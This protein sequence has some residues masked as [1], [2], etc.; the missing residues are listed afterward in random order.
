MNPKNNCVYNESDSLEIW[1]QY[2]TAFINPLGYVIH[3]LAP[4]LQSG[5]A[6][7]LSPI[8]SRY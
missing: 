2:W 8:F 3:G 4:L 7:I 6:S 1:I 5:T